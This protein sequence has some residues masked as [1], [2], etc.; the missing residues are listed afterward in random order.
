MERD[1]EKF[2]VVKGSEGKYQFTEL[3]E[4]QAKWVFLLLFFNRVATKVVTARGGF[5][6]PWGVIHMFS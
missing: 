5:S 3:T 6:E 1:D 2:L 4:A